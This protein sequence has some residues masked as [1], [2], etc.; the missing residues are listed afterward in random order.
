MAQKDGT[1]T[2]QPT[3]TVH[4]DHQTQAR[5]NTSAI[6]STTRKS[7]L[8]GGPLVP[9]LP[10]KTTLVSKSQRCGEGGWI[11][12]QKHKKVQKEPECQ[13]DRQKVKKIYLIPAH[14]QPHIC[15]SHALLEF[16]GTSLQQ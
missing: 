12:Q 14:S 9:S 6:E 4:Q 7:A 5:E 13:G 8:P 16:P 10:V 1:T 3:L 2:V 11:S 15:D